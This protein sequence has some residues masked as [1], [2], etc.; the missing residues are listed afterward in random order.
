MCLGIIMITR[1]EYSNSV[2]MFIFL[3]LAGTEMTS[4]RSGDL[5]F[6]DDSESN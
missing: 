6:L 5:V 4:A 3:E 2:N 1:F